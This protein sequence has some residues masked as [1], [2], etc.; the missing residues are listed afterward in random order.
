MFPDIS[1]LLLYFMSEIISFNFWGKNIELLINKQFLSQYN[2]DLIFFMF[3]M[4]LFFHLLRL[5]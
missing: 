5:S 3:Q 1:I 2:F 4:L